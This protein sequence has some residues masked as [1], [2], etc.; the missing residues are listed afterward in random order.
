MEKHLPSVFL[1]RDIGRARWNRTLEPYGSRSQK[2][3]N[4]P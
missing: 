4:S 1:N 3:K 2:E